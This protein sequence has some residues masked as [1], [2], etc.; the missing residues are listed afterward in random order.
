MGSRA[1]CFVHSSLPEPRPRLV[2]MSNPGRKPLNPRG[3][4]TE[5]PS[6]R[7][8]P[9]LVLRERAFARRSGALAGRI[10]GDHEWPDLG[11]HRGDEYGPAVAVAVTE[12]VGVGKA[13]ERLWL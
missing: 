9:S 8:S 1:T 6:I 13:A 11:D 5:S 4:G 10:S 2:Q 12:A 3:L 7:N